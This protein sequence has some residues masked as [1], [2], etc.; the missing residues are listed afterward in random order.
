MSPDGINTGGWGLRVQA[1][2]M[3]KLGLLL[4]NKGNWNGQRL[5][6]A[7]FVETACSRLIDG[8]AKET[9]PATDGNQGYGYQV[10]Q[11][12]GQALIVP[13]ALLDNIPWWCLKRTLWWSS[14]A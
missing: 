2:T 12:S 8:G 7:D 5:V 3:A 13:M 10:W 11:R 14:W 6:G 4:L 1:E 9:V